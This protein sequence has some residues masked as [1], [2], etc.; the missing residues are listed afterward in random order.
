MGNGV[1]RVI[2]AEVMGEVP[3]PEFF[4]MFRPMD[5]PIPLGAKVEDALACAKLGLDPERA[6]VG[7]Y[8]RALTC[9][10]TEFFIW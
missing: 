6:F 8:M 5:V 7:G 4:E 10:I 9:D 2:H 3:P 1:T